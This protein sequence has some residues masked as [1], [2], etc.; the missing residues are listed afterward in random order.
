MIFEVQPKNYRPVIELYEKSIRFTV[1]EEFQGF[2][3]LMH[4][5]RVKEMEAIEWFVMLA[6]KTSNV[7]M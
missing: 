4:D 2:F 1:N 7:S 5:C 6:P 3:P